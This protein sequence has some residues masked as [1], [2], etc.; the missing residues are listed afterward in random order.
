MLSHVTELLGGLRI[1]TCLW[2]MVSSRFVFHAIKVDEHD[3]FFQ[4]AE[5]P[6]VSWSTV[7]LMVSV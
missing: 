1:E 6:Y 4:V 3:L 7:G 5:W 2:L